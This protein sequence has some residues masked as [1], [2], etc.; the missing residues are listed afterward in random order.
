MGNQTNR[1]RP[2]VME[3]LTDTTHFSE[4]EIRRWYKDFQKD[5]PSGEVSIDQFKKIYSQH[6]PSGDAGK[7]AEH[8]FR[9]FDKD[10]D[11]VLDFREFLVAFSI[12]ANKDPKARLAWA[13]NMY[14]IDQ[15]GYI[16]K[17]ECTEIIKVNN[18]R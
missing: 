5:F 1:L 8:V 17:A 18:V 14:D 6:F 10:S 15:N 12:S 3:D 11:H 16:T 13:F 4:A 7:F 2:E 9:T